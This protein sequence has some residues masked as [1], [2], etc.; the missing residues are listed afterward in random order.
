LFVTLR[1]TA[2]QES[3][4]GLLEL[5]A[6]VRLR[7]VHDAPH[8]VILDE[9]AQPARAHLLHP[10]DEEHVRGLEQ[11]PRH[12]G[13]AVGL[14][15][16]LRQLVVVDVVEHA[17]ERLRARARDGHAREPRLRPP[18]LPAVPVERRREPLGLRRDHQPVRL[19]D[20][21]AHGEL[22][23][24]R[25]P[26]ALEEPHGVRGEVRLGRHRTAG[27]AGPTI[28]AAAAAVLPAAV[29]DI[30]GA[31][32]LDGV[33]VEDAQLRALEGLA[34]DEHAEAPA[35]AAPVEAAGPVGAPRVGDGAVGLEELEGEAGADGAAVRL[36]E[37]LQVEGD[38]HRVG[39]VAVG[40]EPDVPRAAVDGEVAGEDGL[41]GA[42]ALG[43]AVSP[44]RELV[45]AGHGVQ[46]AA[47]VG[48]R[49]AATHRSVDVGFPS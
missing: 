38:E 41:A 4:A 30:H 16:L 35:V 47:G 36:V 45:S 14:D 46:L 49:E 44:D 13:L 34:G 9:A 8:R 6:G 29:H 17:L 33:L 15:Q 18:L 5:L 2:A 27:D 1:P 37:R 32:H 28:I 25:R 39:V 3:A 42:D 31:A 48:R 22:D 11:L 26:A 7:Q 24:E 40:V 20:P 10:L 12:G 23:V 21:A 19:E 43:L